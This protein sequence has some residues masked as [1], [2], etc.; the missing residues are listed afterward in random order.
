MYLIV[1]NFLFLIII[2]CIV[3]ESVKNG[4]ITY[5]GFGGHSKYDK[6][7]SPVQSTKL[8]RTKES[9]SK[10]RKPKLDTGDNKKLNDLIVDI[11]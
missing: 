2:N 7:P 6:F 11:S 10:P 1:T 3:Q 4:S 8:K 9:S 5:D